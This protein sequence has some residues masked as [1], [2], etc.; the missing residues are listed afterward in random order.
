MFNENPD[1]KKNVL[2]RYIEINA[3]FL[4][5][6]HKLSAGIWPIK[7][8]ARPTGAIFLEFHKFERLNVN[9]ELTQ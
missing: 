3:R 6:I 1:F 5:R 7:S 9:S 2:K 4:K 8:S